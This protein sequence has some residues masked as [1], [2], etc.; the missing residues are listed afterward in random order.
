MAF[1]NPEATT[2]GAGT[3]LIGINNIIDSRDIS[4][5]REVFITNLI[6]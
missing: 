4:V 1:H 6:V 5:I 3:V 2:I